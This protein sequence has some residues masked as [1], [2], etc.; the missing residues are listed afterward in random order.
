[1]SVALFSYTK[2]GIS[3]FYSQDA[4]FSTVLQY[5]EPQSFLKTKPAP[6]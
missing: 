3:G 2:G 4:A 6:L 5:L 1:V